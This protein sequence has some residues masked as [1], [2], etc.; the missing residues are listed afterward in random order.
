MKWSNGVVPKSVSPEWS[1]VIDDAL[2]RM[3]GLTPTE[4][5]RRFGVS[6]ATVA[7]WRRRRAAGQTV[8]LIHQ[9]T[10]IRLRQIVEQEYRTGSIP[11]RRR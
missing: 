8:R 4:A 10:R 5:E 1:L 2:R 9:R 11:L 7:T 6:R 3:E